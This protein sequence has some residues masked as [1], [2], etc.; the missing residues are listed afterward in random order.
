MNSK[1]AAQIIREHNKK[2]NV[3][4]THT[5]SVKSFNG[6][7]AQCRRAMCKVLG[8]KDNFYGVKDNILGQ[9]AKEQANRFY[10]REIKDKYFG[11]EVYQSAEWAEYE[12]IKKMSNWEY[13][14]KYGELNIQDGWFCIDFDFGGT[15]FAGL[16]QFALTEMGVFTKEDCKMYLV[17][18]SVLE[19]NQ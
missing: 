10:N 14:R 18:I 17:A 9:Y 12:A 2:D 4:T 13:L 5:Q 7:I 16:S 6:F 8:G 3:Y 11:N 19:K 1:E 15:V